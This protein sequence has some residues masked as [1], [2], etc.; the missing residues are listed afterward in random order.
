MN[1][2]INTNPFLLEPGACARAQ[3]GEASCDQ[4][5]YEHISDKYGG[6]KQQEAGGGEE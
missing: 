4:S 3:A 2:S 1:A 6:A 5:M